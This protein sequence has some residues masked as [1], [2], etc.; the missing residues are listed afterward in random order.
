MPRPA[1]L[2]I[3]RAEASDFEA[4][5][6]TFEDESAYSGTLQV[7]FPSSD[8]WKKRLEGNGPDDYVLLALIDGK[9]AGNAGM[10]APQASPRRAHVRHLGITVR[11]EFQGKGVG[12]ALME[13]LVGLADNWLNVSRLELTVFTDNERAIAL[14]RKHGFEVEGTHKAYALRA[15]TWAD[16]YSMARI[17][18]KPAASQG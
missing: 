7:P 2:V 17:R 11:S 5:R 1:G 12:N 10:H 18:F 9:P 8:V 6:Q 16:V 14:Y 3:R 13:A 4:F 15:G